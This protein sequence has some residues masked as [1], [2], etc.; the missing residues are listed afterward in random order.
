MRT[1]TAVLSIAL[2]ASVALNAFAV[3]TYAVRR[4]ARPRRQPS[5]WVRRARP[6]ARE[7][8]RELQRELGNQMDSLRQELAREQRELA[9]MLRRPETTEAEADS[10]AVR[11]GRLHTAM[12]L[13]AFGHAREAM[14]KL[15]PEQQESLLLRFERQYDRPPHRDRRSSRHGGRDRHRLDGPHHGPPHG[16]QEDEPGDERPGR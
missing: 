14:H 8:L 4:A 15:T 1:S 12:T 2:A 13:T 7:E 3:G 9:M 5:E 11:I 6:E 10:A 16:L